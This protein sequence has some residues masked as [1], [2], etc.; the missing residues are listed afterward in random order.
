MVFGTTQHHL[1]DAAF[2]H[3]QQDGRELGCHHRRVED[4]R[5]RWEQDP[6]PLD[7]LASRSAEHRVNDR[8][9]DRPALDGLKGDV[10]SLGAGECEAWRDG[11]AQPLIL[12]V[13]D[14]CEYQHF[15]TRPPK[16]SLSAAKPPYD[17]AKTP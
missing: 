8:D 5:Q 1:A 13:R 3:L 16:K 14:R 17:A 7:F 12:H 11:A 15:P 10:P 9:F 4:E 6:K 2:P